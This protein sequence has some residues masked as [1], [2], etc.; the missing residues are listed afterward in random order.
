MPVG[1]NTTFAG[2]EKSTIWMPIARSSALMIAS[3]FVRVAFD[4]VH[5]YRNLAGK[6]AHV[7]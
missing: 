3:W 1:P 4:A 5:V 2:F 6:P 7:Q